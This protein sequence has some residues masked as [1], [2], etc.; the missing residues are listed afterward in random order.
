MFT[1]TFPDELARAAGSL[2]DAVRHERNPKFQNSAFL[3]LMQ[4]LRDREVVIEGNDMVAAASASG[5]AADFATADIKGKGK[6]RA[7]RQRWG[8]PIAMGLLIAPSL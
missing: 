3:G 6:G 7:V 4:Q 8:H 2:I 5:W 1:A